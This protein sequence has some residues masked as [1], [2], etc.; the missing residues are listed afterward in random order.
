MKENNHKPKKNYA[1][2]VLFCTISWVWVILLAVTTSPEQIRNFLLPGFYLPMLILL[3][4]AVFFTLSILTMSAKRAIRWTL[5][6]I[7]YL[8]LRLYGLG[9]WLNAA[10][11]LGI[12]TVWEILI[13]WAEKEN[14]TKE[15]V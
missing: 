5:G 2:L 11:I 6:I 3:T 10:L 13:F 9:Y 14:N 12:V 15:V 1:W 8:L 7:L 4:L